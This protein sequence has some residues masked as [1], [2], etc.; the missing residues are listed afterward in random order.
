MPSYTTLS[1]KGMQTISTKWGSISA[2]HYVITDD[3]TPKT[4]T[5]DVWI[6]DGIVL[7]MEQN[8]EGQSDKGTVTLTDTNIK[9]ITG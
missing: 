3:S 8:V 7:K 4:I 6:K 9:A 5:Q 2:H 1:D